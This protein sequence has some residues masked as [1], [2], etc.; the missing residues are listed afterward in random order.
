M[1]QD[2]LLLY[3]AEGSKSH[4]KGN[5]GD[6]YALFLYL[7]K[8]LCCKMKSCCRCCGRT[9]VLSINSLVSVL[10]LK[11]VSDVRWK[12]SVTKKLPDF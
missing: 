2:I 4:M 7:I 1:I 5:M 3:G 10:V 6:L 9:V 12:R 11:L 8:K